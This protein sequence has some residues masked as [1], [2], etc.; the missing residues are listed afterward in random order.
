MSLLIKIGTPATEFRILEQ[1][2]LKQFLPAHRLHN[3]S[4]SA[5]FR[6]CIF[7]FHAV[8]IGFRRIYVKGVEKLFSLATITLNSAIFIR[9]F[10]MTSRALAVSSFNMNVP[11]TPRLFLGHGRRRPSSQEV[12]LLERSKA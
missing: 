11:I 10:G 4:F 1:E 8:N 6:Y 9:S 7:I 5:F 12:Y 3:L 2:T